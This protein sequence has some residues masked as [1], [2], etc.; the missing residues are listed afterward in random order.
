[1]VEKIIIKQ[2]AL[3]ITGLFTL[4]RPPATAWPPFGE[5]MAALF[6]RFM[7]PRRPTGGKAAMNAAGSDDCAQSPEAG[8]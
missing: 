2:R 5:V 1:M 3:R 8:G 4:C 7:S 6:L